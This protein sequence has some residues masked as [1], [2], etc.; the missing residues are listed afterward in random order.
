MPHD[1]ISEDQPNMKVPLP[2]EDELLAAGYAPIPT[3]EDLLAKGFV[4]INFRNMPAVENMTTELG[5]PFPQH[6]EIIK[7]GYV[8]ISRRERR[9]QSRPRV[10]QMY[11][12]DF[13]HDAYVPEFVNE[14][15]GIVIR[16][17]NSLHD[18]CIILPVT[19][20]Q[21]QA[22]THFHQL[23]K[24]PN[25]KGHAEGRT[26]YV[27]CDH[28]YTVNVNRLRAILSLKGSPVFPKVEAHDMTAIFGIVEK[29]LVLASA[30]S[31]A[32]ATA[33][34]AASAT[35][36]KALGPNTLTLGKK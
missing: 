17:A 12:V 24:N 19:S 15:P 16:A 8:P 18:T 27:V 5:H 30:P 3:N 25:P 13:P 35:P 26:A 31:H 11:W 23:S 6:H 21:Q 14:H 4:P 10:G 7:A 9:I 32:A 36:A 22:G 29:V 28:L 20:A 2:T 34:T 33:A 1:D